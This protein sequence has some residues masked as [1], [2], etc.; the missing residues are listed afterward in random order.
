MPLAVVKRAGEECFK[1]VVKPAAVTQTAF[2]GIPA[3]CLSGEFRGP[4]IAAPLGNHVDDCDE[5]SCAVNR[6]TWAPDDFDAIH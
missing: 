3:S 4:Q 2:V 1:A 6:R 5:C